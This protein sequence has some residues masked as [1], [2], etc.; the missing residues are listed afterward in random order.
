MAQARMRLG[1]IGA[2]GGTDRWGARAHLPAV[3]ALEEAE[4]AAVCTSR[5]ETARHA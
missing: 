3:L 2:N 4:L 5:E 1:V